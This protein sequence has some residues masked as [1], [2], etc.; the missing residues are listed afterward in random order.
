MGSST[1]F[2]EYSK[3]KPVLCMGT[4]F[5]LVAQSRNNHGS[6]VRDK[7]DMSYEVTETDVFM[8]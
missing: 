5:M 6:G 3:Y 1:P 2:T 4:F 8:P 7:A